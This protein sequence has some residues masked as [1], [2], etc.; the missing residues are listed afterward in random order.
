[1]TNEM[2]PPMAVG[3]TAPV[4]RLMPEF[5]RVGDTVA[6]DVRH[7]YPRTISMTLET[8]AAAAHA[9]MLLQDKAR[10]WRLVRG[11]R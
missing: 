1:M 4:G 10:G 3:S 8:P 7:P 9:S 2:T 5:A 11:P 6:C